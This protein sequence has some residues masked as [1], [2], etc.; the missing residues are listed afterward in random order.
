MNVQMPN[1]RLSALMFATQQGHREVVELL[2]KHPKIAVELQDNAGFTALHMAAHAGDVKLLLLLLLRDPGNGWVETRCK[3]E[4][5]GMTALD[6]AR[7]ANNEAAVE[8]LSRARARSGKSAPADAR[9]CHSGW[10]STDTTKCMCG[11]RPAGG[12]DLLSTLMKSL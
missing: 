11:C 4:Y 7:G 10:D 12:S 9:G 6:V 3:P 2:L 1:H 8:L 5:G